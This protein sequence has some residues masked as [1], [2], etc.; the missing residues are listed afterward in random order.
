M[1]L[2][3]KPRQGLALVRTTVATRQQAETLAQ[4]LVRDHVAACVHLQDVASVYRWD[5]RVQQ[6]SEVLVE[7][8]TTWERRIDVERIMLEGHP[9][10]T[11]VVEAWAVR[12]VPA[13]YGAWA[14][15]EVKD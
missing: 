3:R 6:E 14:A 2:W 10:E 15:R 5:G 9:Y 13:D 7:A 11:P 8:R 4:R 1:A 12:D